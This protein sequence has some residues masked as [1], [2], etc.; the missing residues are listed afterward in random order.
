MVDR[1]FRWTECRF[2]LSGEPVNLRQRAAKRCEQPTAS[3]IKCPTNGS[4][5]RPRQPVSGREP[6]CI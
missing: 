6:E 2:A 3:A 5:A 1:Y 4:L